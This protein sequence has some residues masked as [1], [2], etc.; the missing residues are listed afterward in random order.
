[1][2]LRPWAVG[3][4]PAGLGIV[5]A[6]DDS[7]MMR[8]TPLKPGPGPKRRTAVK[9]RNAKRLRETRARQFGPHAERVRA[10]PCCA[11]GARPPSQPHHVKSRGAGGTWRDLVPLC[12]YCHLIIHAIGAKSFGRAHNVDLAAVARELAMKEE[13]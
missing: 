8:R 6:V 9:K 1:M 2:G 11:C 7:A 3:W 12:G 5:C 13:Q 4:L 10:L